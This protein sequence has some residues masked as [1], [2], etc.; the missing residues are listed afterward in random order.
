LPDPA[1]RHG[2]PAPSDAAT[3]AFIDH[4]ALC[5]AAEIQDDCVDFIT[6]RPG[7]TASEM[8]G[9][10]PSMV[11]P[12]ADTMALRILEAVCAASTGDCVVPYAPHAIMDALNAWVPRSVA[13]PLARKL[14]SALGK[15]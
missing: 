10:Q 9:L 4:W 11:A 15:D 7:I 8:T 13:W 5:C 1:P 3:K 2:L 6:V 14:N 12:A